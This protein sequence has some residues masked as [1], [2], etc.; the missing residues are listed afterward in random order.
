MKLELDTI[1]N[2]MN[3]L[4]ELKEHKII[5]LVDYLSDG[6]CRLRPNVLHS[7]GAVYVFWWTGR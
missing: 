3:E 6:S 7:T 2:G 4:K 5:N 1:K